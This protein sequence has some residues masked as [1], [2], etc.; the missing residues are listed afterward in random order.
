MN[1]ICVIGSVNMDMVFQVERFVKAKETI[2]SSQMEIFLGGKGLNQSV[3]FRKA[4]GHVFLGGN[5]GKVDEKLIEKISDYGID[6][7]LLSLVDTNTGTAFIQVDE[8]GQNCIVLHKGANH[9][10]TKEQID[11]ILGHF[12]ANDLIVLQ[13]ETNLLEYMIRESKKRGLLIALNPSPFD[14]TIERLPLELVDYILLN[15]VE[16]EELT[17]KVDPND[18]LKFME[19][20]YPNTC[21]V[22]TLGADGV[23]CSKQQKRFFQKSQQVE[24]VD[25]TAAGDTFTGYFLASILEEKDILESLRVATFAAGISVTRKGA[26]ASI[27]SASEVMSLM[28]KCDLV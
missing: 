24:V 20:K 15:E 22:L 19:S 25:S 1:K 9:K 4:Y 13:N 2:S 18:I 23:L 26:T 16:G 6:T 12:Q 17:G 11:F 14:E 7:S 3:A 5:I 27:P 28:K 8:H 21:V 10:F